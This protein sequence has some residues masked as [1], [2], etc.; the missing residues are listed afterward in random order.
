MTVFKVACRKVEQVSV[1]L[2]SFINLFSCS[3]TCNYFSQFWNSYEIFAM[4]L[5]TWLFYLNKC[6][7]QHYENQHNFALWVFTFYMSL[8]V[9]SIYMFQCL[10]TVYFF[11]WVYFACKSSWKAGCQF[12]IIY[13]LVSVLLTSSYFDRIATITYSAKHQCSSPFRY[14]LS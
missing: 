7:F 3:F 13:N 10:T 9:E 1:D 11:K 12:Y 2:C 6:C 14:P 4:Q 5:Y 8:H